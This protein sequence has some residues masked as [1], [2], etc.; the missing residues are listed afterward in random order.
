[1]HLHS[2]NYLCS[3]VYPPQPSEETD[4]PSVPEADADRSPSPSWVP[5]YSVS[6][7]GASPLHSPRVEAAELP[8]EPVQEVEPVLSVEP[9]AAT[10][11]EAVPIDPIPEVVVE[12]T[13]EPIEEPKQAVETIVEPEVAEEVEPEAEQSVE[14]IAAEEEVVD[15]APTP[16]VL[17]TTTEDLPAS[18][19]PVEEEATKSSPWIPSYSVSSQG[20]SP[21]H[22]PQETATDADVAEIESLP[23]AVEAP[24]PEEPSAPAAEPEPV[25]VEEPAVAEESAPVDEPVSP[26]P[27]E[28]AE[29]ATETPIIVT[30][31]A[32]EAVVVSLKSSSRNMSMLKHVQ[33][34]T[35]PTVAVGDERPK[36]PWTPSYSVSQQGGSPLHSPS[37][38]HK[39]L[40]ELEVLPP[41]VQEEFAL[42][43]S[44][45]AEQP[46]IRIDETPAPVSEVSSG[47]SLWRFV[48]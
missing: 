40:Q 23:A 47:S 10:V 45:P 27:V 31:E 20:S 32:D 38:V 44:V 3:F 35:P 1:M 16:E 11:E 29:P 17:I 28:E 22:T 7:Q 39:E 2:Q 48:H 37:P 5:S 33:P 4:E 13:A 24:A 12:P 19:A 36:S 34:S 25:V 6:A 18:E 30:E 41:P 9:E 21:L 8:E 15:E 14:D 46:E 42:A 26:A 43:E